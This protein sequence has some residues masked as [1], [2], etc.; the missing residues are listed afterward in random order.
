MHRYPILRLFVARAMPDVLRQLVATMPALPFTPVTNVNLLAN[1]G[2]KRASL[3]ENQLKFEA[4]MRAGE[5]DRRPSLGARSQP[6]SPAVRRSVRNK[7]RRPSQ[8]GVPFGIGSPGLADTSTFG[9]NN[10]VVPGSSVESIEFN[11]AFLRENI[12]KLVQLMRGDDG[13]TMRTILQV[14][15]LLQTALGLDEKW[16]EPFFPDENKAKAKQVESFKNN[17]F[18]LMRQILQRHPKIVCAV[19]GESPEVGT[20]LL[21]IDNDG[22][23]FKLFLQACA[24]AHPR[25]FQHVL[26]QVASA[27]AELADAV[28]KAHLTDK[29]ALL[30]EIL[31]SQL[32]DQGGGQGHASVVAGSVVNEV[33]ALQQATILKYIA[34]HPD[35]I[36]QFFQHSAPAM[37][38]FMHSPLIGPSDK[39]GPSEGEVQ[40]GGEVKK[41]YCALYIYIYVVRHRTY[42]YC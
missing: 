6:V 2:Q 23:K 12:T 33:Q 41:R 42:F 30:H 35:I 16:E 37:V 15:M 18:R 11:E 40:A 22:T 25:V 21:K 4:M 38:G 34:A 8:N 39:S 14:P 10:P 24:T 1:V 31:A 7:Q 32:D 29:P 36:G 26:G 3:E 19:L 13:S 17:F 27:H 9:G 5:I 28:A 20:G